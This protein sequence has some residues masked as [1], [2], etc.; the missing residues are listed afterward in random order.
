[1]MRCAPLVMFRHRY[2]ARTVGHVLARR[3][4]GAESVVMRCPP[5]G[6]ATTWRSS[7]S[8]VHADRDLFWWW[9]AER[10]AERILYWLRTE[11]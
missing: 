1:M 9:Q 5:V 10:R 11:R 6:V 4:P 7:L 2:S 3:T 8:A